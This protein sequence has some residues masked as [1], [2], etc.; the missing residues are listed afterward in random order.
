MRKKKCYKNCKGTEC[1]GERERERIYRDTKEKLRVSLPLETNKR[2]RLFLYLWCDTLQNV[3][4]ERDRV[5]ING[6]WTQGIL[7]GCSQVGFMAH[8]DSTRQK[9]TRNQSRMLI[10]SSG[11]DLVR[12]WIVLVGFGFIVSNVILAGSVEIW[13]DHNEIS[14][15]LVEFGLD[16]DEISPDVIEFLVIF[17]G[18]FQI[19]PIFVSFH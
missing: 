14:P 9:R 18:E 17:I 6:R 5:E 15:N 12:F 11:S 10:R 2:V 19:L 7:Y 8:L 16:L 4:T 1:V 13:P 3:E